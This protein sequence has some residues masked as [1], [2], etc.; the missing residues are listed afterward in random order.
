VQGV[1]QGAYEQVIRQT[2]EL[3]RFALNLEAEVF[4]KFCD[5]MVYWLC[6]RRVLAGT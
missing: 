2:F 6:M 4:S 3:F 1:R 5:V